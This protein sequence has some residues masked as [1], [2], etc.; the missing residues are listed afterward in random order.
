MALHPTLLKW[1]NVVSYTTAISTMAYYHKFIIDALAGHPNFLSN[2]HA[3]FLIPTVNWVLL[4]GF[5]FLVQ[6]FDATHDVVVEAVDWHLF[7][8]NFVITG[9]VLSWVHN[10]LYV[11]QV[12][13]IV[14]AALIWR[15]YARM[16]VF[17]AT[18]LLE[19]FCVYVAFSIYT[20]LVWLDVFQNFFAAFTTKEGGPES[21]AAWGAAGSLLVLLMIGTYFIEFARDPDSWVG[22]TIAV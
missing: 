8:S 13:L 9:W 7:V 12:L 22:A 17:T 6:W 18:S 4:G 19:H 3:G 20:A 21:L 2:S 5:T 1:L 10:S 14:N 11:G 15:L 16:R